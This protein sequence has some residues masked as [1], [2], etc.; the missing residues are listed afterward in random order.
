MKKKFQQVATVSHQGMVIAFARDAEEGAKGEIYFNVLDLRV[1]SASDAADWSGFTRLEFPGE[2][3]PSGLGIVTVEDTKGLILGAAPTPFKV[4]SDQQYVCVFRQSSKNTL[5]LNRFMLKRVTEPGSRVPV[6]KLEPAWEVRFERSGKQD[7]PASLRDSQNYV[8]PD[9]LPFIEPTL[10]LPMISNVAEGKFDVVI[11][12]SETKALGTWQF[13]AVDSVT[14][15]LNFFSIP[16][17]DLGLFDLTGK[18]LDASGNIL[19]DQSIALYLNEHLPAQLA[20]FAYGPSALVYSV[21]ER[22]T[23]ANGESTLLKRSGRTMVAIGV[24]APGLGVRVATL[25]LGISKSGALAQAPENLVATLV[26]PANYALD[27]GQSA[28]L[29]LQNHGDSLSIKGNYEIETWIYPTSGVAEDQIILG[30]DPGTAAEKAAPYLKVTRE[31]KLA[32]GFGDGTQAVA[33]RSAAPVIALG[34]WTKVAMRYDT[35]AG[36]TLWINDQIVPQEGGATGVLP[37]GNPI[38]TVSGS[39][40]GFVGTLDGLTIRQD[41]SGTL[42]EVGK[43]AFDTVAYGDTPPTTPDTSTYLNKGL[44][45]GAMLVPAMSPTSRDTQGAMTL[46]SNGLTVFT[47]ILPFV[48]PTASPFLLS[49]SDGLLHLYYEAPDQGFNVVQYD[50]EAARA[51]FAS[52]WTTPPGTAVQTGTLRYLSTRSGTF[53]N[54]AE[55]TVKPTGRGELCEVRFDNGQGTVELWKGVPRNLDTFLDILGGKSTS[56]PDDQGF[57][58]GTKAFYDSEARYPVCRTLAHSD[59]S[60]VHIVFLSRL[61]QTLPLLSVE[62]KDLTPEVCT[63]V[64]QLEAHRFWTAGAPS[65]IIQTWTGV[66]IL[67]AELQQV[68]NGLSGTYDYSSTTSAN[69]GLY[70]IPAGGA[71]NAL[72]PV[73]FLTQPGVTEFTVTVSEGSSPELCHV[74][75]GLLAADKTPLTGTWTDIPRQQE[76]FAAA[77][78]A[79]Q[80][81]SPLLLV[82]TDGLSAY[83]LNHLSSPQDAANMLAW[84]STFDVYTDGQIGGLE[85]TLA[86]GPIPAQI[87]Q[88]ATTTTGGVTEVLTSGSRLFSTLAYTSPTNGAKAMVQDTAAM[89]G[90]KVDLVVAAVNGGWINESPRMAVACKGSNAIAWDITDARINALAIPGDMSLGTWCKPKT[91][92]SLGGA[93]LLTYN[94]LGTPD[95]P[96]ERVQYALGLTCAPSLRFD[97]STGFVGSYNLA[98]AD[99]TLQAWVQPEQQGGGQVLTLS[100]IGISKPYLSLKVD[101]DQKAVLTYGSGLGEVTSVTRLV[102]GTW[103]QLTGV[104]RE[105][106]GQAQVELHLYLNGVE[107]GALTLPKGTFDRVPGA[108]NAGSNATAMPML[109]NGFFMWKRALSASE[110]RGYFENAAPENGPDLVIAWYLTEG[111][112]STVTNLAVEGTPF[113]ST[114]Q[115]QATEPWAPRG[116]YW[117]PYAANRAFALVA[118]ERPLLTGWRQ[119]GSM[120]R[121]AYALHFTGQDHVDCGNDAS[122]NLD[123]SISLE[124]WIRPDHVDS[125][126]TLISK[127]GAYE[128]GLNRDNTLYFSIQTSVGL[129]R[130]ATAATLKAGEV[131]YVAATVSTGPKQTTT[132]SDKPVLQ[133]Y[134]LD[135][136]VYL[137]GVVSASFHKDDYADPVS[138]STS[139]TRLNLGRSTKGAAYYSGFLSEVRLWQIALDAATIRQVFQLHTPPASSDGLVSYWRFAEMRGTFVGDQ[140]DLNNGVVTSNELWALFPEASAL[141]ISVDG[142]PSPT[143]PISLAEIGGYGEDQFTAGALKTGA[144]FTLGFN[145]QIDDIRVWNVQLTPEQVADNLYR[146]LTGSEAGLAGYW[147]FNTGSGQLVDDGTGHGNTGRLVPEGNLPLWGTSTAPL[148]NEAKEVYNSLGGVRTAFQIRISG[149][150]SVVEYADTQRDAYGTLFSVMKRCYVSET[151]GRVNLVTGYKVGDLDT[152]YAGQVQTQP[153]LIGYI[154]GAPPIPSENE[155][156]PYWSEVTC[157]NT[158]AGNCSIKLIQADN[159]VL[160]YSGSQNSGDSTTI[161]GKVGA[162]ISTGSSASF[163]VGAETEWDTWNIEGHLG[164]VGETAAGKSAVEELGFGYGKTR[165]LTDVVS[166]GGTWE[167]KELILNP[168][169]GRRYIPDN[170]GYALVKS[171]TA[172]LYMVRLKGSNSVVKLSIVPNLDIPEDVNIISFPIDPTYTKN[173]TLDGMV[174]F[175]TDPSYPYAN[176]TRGS[177]FKPIEAYQLKRNIQKQDK[178]LEG[179]FKQF[180]TANLSKG[181]GLSDIGHLTSKANARTGFKE[182]RDDFLPNEPAYDWSRNLS[183]RNIANTYV[184]NANAGY[185]TEEESVLDNYTESYSGISNW[186]SSDGLHFDLQTAFIAGIYTEFD[187]LWIASLEVMSMKTKASDRSFGLEVAF[188]PE[189][190]LK[191]P[192]VDAEGQPV[193]YTPADAPGKVD[194]YRFMSF[195]LA[196][197]EDNFRQF[198]D[199]VVDKNWLKNSSDPGAAALSQASQDT[200]GTWRAFHRVTYVSRIPQP[201]LPG[202]AESTSPPIVPPANVADNTVLTRLVEREVGATPT[203]SPTQ[204]GAAVDA[205]LGQSVASPGQLAAVLPWWTGFLAAAEDT[206]STAYTTLLTLRGDLLNYMIQKYQSEAYALGGAQFLRDSHLN[207]RRPIHG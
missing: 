42:T 75:I 151:Q 146:P 142:V 47:G 8:A 60:D 112:G 63:V 15:R 1:A 38:S 100:T 201:F 6:V 182:F 24:N 87:L 105:V 90:G 185:H 170:L 107:E 153:S 106:P 103:Y 188:N 102:V 154:E 45:Y 3:R 172:D 92:P 178:Q 137:D 17:N 23:S 43:W 136:Q 149:S 203:P 85:K 88:G 89:P 206:R 176:L 58:A 66:P 68:L 110:V 189:S 128:I 143:V 94:R 141:W 114:I 171:L 161:S 147:P 61:I 205:V 13:F 20:P 122:L 134:V 65:T 14:G 39:V 140:H 51:V 168:E 53:M 62:I 27:F 132:S 179:Y 121:S 98:G 164:Y 155:T 49:G 36:F 130:L 131:H 157:I 73:L 69:A 120:Y 50:A 86:Q 118:R 83:V 64:V 174:G 113:V 80:P 21:Q 159:T 30:G 127:P 72:H 181:L 183:R 54:R 37:F 124:T 129:M 35:T 32:A 169:V 199:R 148:S 125:V 180:S 56:N 197:T 190:Y 99:C 166:P 109:A 207:Q 79:G 156:A 26:S 46:D 145:G 41:I 28:Y 195:F 123:S 162:Y 194:G 59:V 95:F 116:A 11:L 144:A 67:G 202:P 70:S 5:L 167:P 158:Y 111:Q 55:I 9:G 84:A 40:N 44:I 96:S 74:A 108:L 19:P 187:A 177:Y 191:C 93:R 200:N 12:P 193:G 160:S 138:L 48:E 2:L 7:I 77:L 135:I 31:L 52:G 165:T 82:I 204:I 175:K 126:Q 76:A 101:G 16:M 152:I 91:S 57:K 18:P 97:T 163:G 34:A 25:D 117:V 173:G 4:V 33:C 119:V 196:P 186:N 78:Q 192:V 10:E 104:L 184:W 81:V 22:L 115:N 71:S 133:T 29:T 198:F 139:K 150:P